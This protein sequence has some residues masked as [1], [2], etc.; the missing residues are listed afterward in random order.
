[1]N[2]GTHVF[3]GTASAVAFS[4]F[5][6]KNDI[7]HDFAI[8]AY[9]A[10][11]SVLPDVDHP[12]AWFSNHFPFIS[13]LICCFL[14]LSGKFFGDDYYQQ[15]LKMHRGICHS[16]AACIQI[17]LLLF[18]LF[19]VNETQL[20]A[21]GLCW[22]MLLHILADSGSPMGCM[23][24][25]PF[26]NKFYS[27]AAKPIYRG[28]ISV[29]SQNPYWH[30]LLYFCNLLISF[31]VIF[32]FYAVL[33]LGYFFKSSS[34]TAFDK[35]ML[36]LVIYHITMHI[37]LRIFRRILVKKINAAYGAGNDED[38]YDDDDFL[39]H[40]PCEYC[41]AEEFEYP[42]DEDDGVLADADNLI[43]SPSF[44]TPPNSDINTQNIIPFHPRK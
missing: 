21:L 24:F 39:E 23:L 16:F 18:P 28:Y 35:V 27:S 13:T 4:H 6:L 33:I 2:T 17:S 20:F 14:G 9:T 3:L 40:S 22:G 42:N 34:H 29:Y 30:I 19:F 31:G 5:V 41:V 15:T 7:P 10:L 25:A 37:A 1:M 43:D 8:G 32:N 44:L 38:F 36:L 26:S 11:G 12:N